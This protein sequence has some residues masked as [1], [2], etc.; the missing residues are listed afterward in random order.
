MG[1][2]RYGDDEAARGQPVEVGLHHGP[3]RP[4]L[5]SRRDLVQGEPLRAVGE[6]RQEQGSAMS[7]DVCPPCA[8]GPSR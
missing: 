8:S 1:V 2:T 5:L 7:E 3:V 6:V 4:W